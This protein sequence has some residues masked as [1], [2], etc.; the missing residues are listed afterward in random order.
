MIK[1]LYSAFT[2]LEAAWQYQDV[3]ANNVANA[4]TIGYKRELGVQQSFSDVLLS[5]QAP[6]PAPLSARIEAVVGQI[7][8]GTFIAE[9][10]TDYAPGSLQA[11]GQELDLALTDG[12]FAVRDEQGQVFYTRDGRFSRDANGDLVT[13]H[14]LFVLDQA[15]DPIRI[16]DG[17][18]S[19]DVDGVISTGEAEVARLQVI[20][21]TPGSLTRAGEAYFT[22]DTP[23]TLVQGGIRQGY[24][25]SSN[26]DMV[27]ELTTLLAVQRTYQANQ[28]VLRTLDG[29]LDQAAG[30]LG[31]L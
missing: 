14:G 1:G 12:F 16:P 24:L 15:G 4:T 22:S 26:T 2:A 9:F 29:T 5:Q 28:T 3:L 7:G 10:S 20:D 8:T 18:T 23:G 11:T 27:E 30:D 6:T 31:T 19:V 25:E 21:F 17:A 13:S